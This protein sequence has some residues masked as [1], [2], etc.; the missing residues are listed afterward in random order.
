MA[1]RA[2]GKSGRGN[3]DLLLNWSVEFHRLVVST[4]CVCVSSV[5]EDKEWKRVKMVGRRSR[6]FWVLN[7]VD[8]LDVSFTY[9]LTTCFGDIFNNACSVIDLV[10]S[11]LLLLLHGPCVLMGP[12]V[13]GSNVS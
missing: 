10:L 2:L 5:E 6:R 7:S 13:P 4:C 12:W 9:Y 8:Y 1:V 3:R 11:L